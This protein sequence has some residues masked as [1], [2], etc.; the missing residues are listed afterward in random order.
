MK[1]WKRALSVSITGVM[2]AAAPM[3]ALAASPEFART[4]EEWARL[5]DNKMEYDELEDLIA[6][7]N[8]TI[9]IPIHIVSY[10]VN[11]VW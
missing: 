9:L 3:T 2:L 11:F 6:E 1:I 10:V 8:T 7:Y 4:S 5:R